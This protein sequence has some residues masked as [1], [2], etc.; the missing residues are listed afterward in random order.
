MPPPSCPSVPRSA[1]AMPASLLFV[2][3]RL[4]H[5]FSPPN[6]HARPLKRQASKAT[7]TFSALSRAF[8][9]L[10]PIF[11]KK[12][13]VRISLQSESKRNSVLR[14]YRTPSI[15]PFWFNL[16]MIQTRE[17][18]RIAT[19]CPMN[20]R[21]SLYLA[22]SRKNYRMIRPMSAFPRS[23]WFLPRPE[24]RRELEAVGT[25]R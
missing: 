5:A 6:F 11:I 12:H 22:R 7:A 2:I 16:N 24:T 25:A 23:A 19:L 18:S 8:T 17:R 20:N 4:P 10:Y 1:R 3:T 14:L 9:V 21:I 13:C 15:S